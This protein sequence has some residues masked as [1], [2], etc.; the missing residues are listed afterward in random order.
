[1]KSQK[2]HFSKITENAPWESPRK[3]AYSEHSILK[4]G[5]V[6]A[7]LTFVPTELRA[8]E[9]SSFCEFWKMTSCDFTLIYSFFTHTNISFLDVLGKENY[10]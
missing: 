8:R 9:A 6:T 7:I 3:A 5:Y 1:M 4:V 10:S 2:G